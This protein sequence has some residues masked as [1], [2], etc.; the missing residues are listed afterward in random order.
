MGE[1]AP[2]GGAEMWLRPG[3]RSA[4]ES[5]VFRKAQ[6]ALSAV[7]RLHSPLKG[8]ILGDNLSRSIP[9]TVTTRIG[10]GRTI[11][12]EDAE[13][14]SLDSTSPGKAMRGEATPI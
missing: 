1:A 10:A 2:K 7:R 13:G 14:V 11:R 12:H 5:P 8:R 6:R 4:Q 3:R 9:A